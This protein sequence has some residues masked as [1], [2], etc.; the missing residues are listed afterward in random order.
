MAASAESLLLKASATKEGPHQ[1]RILP[2]LQFHHSLKK[3]L[4]CRA[5]GNAVHMLHW[6]SRNRG[7]C[8]HGSPGSRC[9]RF[10]LIS[11]GHSS[12]QCPGHHQRSDEAAY[13]PGTHAVTSGGSEENHKLAVSS[14]NHPCGYRSASATARVF[15]NSQGDSP[16]EAGQNCR[17][18][19]FR[20]TRNGIPGKSGMRG[21]VVSFRVTV[22][23]HFCGR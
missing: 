14:A 15:D 13:I 5:T 3:T 17:S 23:I 1:P 7:G 9:R 16:Q 8:R 2:T 22:R 11:H 6:R 19:P 4:R 21:V 18:A 20:G 12:H 10:L